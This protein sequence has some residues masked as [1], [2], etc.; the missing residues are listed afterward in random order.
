MS[1]AQGDA[2]V[3][4]SA[5]VQ[6]IKSLEELTDW[7]ETLLCNAMPMQHCMQTEWDATVKR[8]RDEKYGVSTP[9]CI[10]EKGI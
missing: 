2:D 10:E 8:W 9:T 5:C 6:R 4:L 7:A 3:M 1:D